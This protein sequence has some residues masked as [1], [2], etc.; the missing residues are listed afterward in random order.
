MSTSE[1]PKF[2]QWLKIENSAGYWTSPI[3]S[4][5]DE[6][7]SESLRHWIKWSSESRAEA[8]SHLGDHEGGFLRGYSERM[9]TLA[10]RERSPKLIFL[11]LV[12]LGLEGG[13]FDWRENLLVISLHYDAANRIGEDADAIFREAAALFEAEI[14]NAIMEYANRSPEGK[15]IKSMGYEANGDGDAFQYVR[16]W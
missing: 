1:S 13:R 16:N 8:R 10:V 2:E 9:A 12:A 11:G 15:T 7:I 4:H 3:P 6:S 14:G 5:L